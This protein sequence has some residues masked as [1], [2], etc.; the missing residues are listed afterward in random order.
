MSITRAVGGQR[1][2]SGNKMDVQMHGYERSTHNLS[3]V[4]R[5]SSTVGTLVP[6]MTEIGL[7]GDKFDIDLNAMIRTIPT[8]APLFG[9]FK[10]QLDVFE[11][12]IRLYNGL[13]HNNAINI[14]LDMSK[15]KFPTMSIQ[16]NTGRN[17]QRP[18]D[19]QQIA[20]D[21][22][23]AYLGVR[24]LGTYEEAQGDIVTRKFNAVPILAY[25][26]IFKQ[27]YAN[28]QEDNA[29]VIGA[30]TSTEANIT[31]LK[32]FRVTNGVGL[33]TKFDPKTDSIE[34][35]AN[36]LL[37]LTGKNLDFNEIKFN[38]TDA[39]DIAAATP[40][41]INTATKVQFKVKGTFI[42]TTYTANQIGQVGGYVETG[43]ITLNEFPLKNIDEMRTAILRNTELGTT[44]EISDFDG[45]P[46]DQLT[47]MTAIGNN[48]NY[49]NLNG[50]CVKTY[51]SDIFNNWINTEWLD[52]ENGINAITAVSTA[53][54]E[55]TIDSLNL[56]KK[57]YD[58]LNRIALSGGTYEDWQEVN[59][60]E[61]ALRRAES[62]IYQGGMSSEIVF[63]EL[64][65]TAETTD[66]PLG[67]LAGRGNLTDRKG[68][69]IE[70]ECKE[71]CIIMGIMSITPRID[72]SQG[73]KWYMTEL[74][75]M[76]DLHKPALDG[77]GFQ[78]LM[79]EQMA[80]WDVKITAG[81]ELA[82]FSA[83]KQPA[84][85]NY[86]TSYNEVYGTFADPDKAGYTVLRR[87]YEQD[88]ETTRIKDLT[89]YIDPTKYNYAFASNNLEEQ[90]FWVQ[91]GM[92]IQARRKM[93]AKIIPNL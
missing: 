34:I 46:Y 25:Y 74:D 43:V 31:E 63:E 67:T 27:Y 71:P 73:N 26:D 86:M 44:F 88:P 23:M 21:S 76:N 24:G 19:V 56:A 42:T 87:N 11:V 69:R 1:L 90:N 70:I 2:G 84:W 52:G 17:R 32:R 7:N 77:I 61:Q 72:Y 79:T 14:G 57:V 12:P 22:L 18:L 65:S 62:P 45:L 10:L 54:D 29:Y 49:F 93:S 58:M 85:L 81:N 4:F 37:E 51:Q 20:P 6:F 92:N 75:N 80:W 89:T 48:Y 47:G 3:R 35:K 78:E 41:P 16:H 82:K 50:L 5:S 28:K 40:T 64:V 59:Y 33:W 9:T 53:G 91:I 83:G 38:T 68:G 55:F 66:K 15:V 13:L 36:D 30:N 60:G 39:T 8:I